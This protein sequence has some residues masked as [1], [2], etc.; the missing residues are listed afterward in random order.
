MH[1]G[2]WYHLLALGTDRPLSNH[3]MSPCT[4]TEPGWGTLIWKSDP[5]ALIH[6]FLFVYLKKIVYKH[7]LGIY[8]VNG[9]AILNP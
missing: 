4:L 6:L 8:F 2:E 3:E 1:L 5:W 7:L 9:G